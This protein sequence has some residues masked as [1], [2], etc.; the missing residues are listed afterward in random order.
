M[1][2]LNSRLNSSR[3][4]N[5]LLINNRVSNRMKRLNNKLSRSMVSIPM[6]RK[7]RLDHSQKL[8]LINKNKVADIMADRRNECW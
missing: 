3:V 1:K 8:P 2:R 6:K 4:N 7:N 5:S